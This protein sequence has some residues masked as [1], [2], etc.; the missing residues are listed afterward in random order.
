MDI[1]Q[2]NEKN[3]KCFMDYYLKPVKKIKLRKKLL[4]K[5]KKEDIDKLI[6]KVKSGDMPTNYINEELECSLEDGV[7]R[8]WHK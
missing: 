6:A 3:K 5:A 1:K 4:K 8:P 7:I 2:Y